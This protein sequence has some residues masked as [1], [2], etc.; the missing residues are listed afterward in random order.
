MAIYHCE[1][2]TISRKSGRSST[3]AAAYRAGEK[4][5]D[6]RTL[7]VFDYTKKK[8]VISAN[9]IMPSNVTKKITRSELWNLAESAEKRKDATVAREYI[10]AIP[11]E[12]PREAQ[13][14]LALKF[15]QEL[16]DRYHI[17]ADVALHAP[18]R[19]GDER[20]VHAHILTTTR[21]I[22]ESGELADKTREL[23]G[24]A[25]GRQQVTLIR[26]LWAQ[27]AN[28]ALERHG[29]SERIDH[30]TLKEQGID[31]QPQIH[32]GVHATQMERR[33]IET[34][35][36]SRNKEIQ[37]HNGELAE[38]KQAITDHNRHIEEYRRA[39]EGQSKSRQADTPTRNPAEP[40]KVPEKGSYTPEQ[41][42]AAKKALNDAQ[43]RHT[44]RLKKQ[45]DEDT[46]KKIAPYQVLYAGKV[47]ERDELEKA[48]PKKKLF[49]RQSVYSGRRHVW[50]AALEAKK[51]E[52]W[53][54]AHAI[55]QLQEEQNRVSFS[56]LPEEAYKLACK[57]HPEA[58][59]IV[60]W[61]KE[62]EK[63]L[64]ELRLRERLKEREKERKQDARSL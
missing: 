32:V 17:A 55:E 60:A 6:G 5:K 28:A 13:R 50:S 42:I 39:T 51:S 1:V 44:E 19:R 12:L 40:T 30:R 58:A 10:I 41:V 59:K 2:K 26:E 56:V 20:N 21:R 36:G 31:R 18:D 61:D 34:E 46:A 11:D 35:K 29:R 63:E 24:M 52:L 38:I 47:K 23:D 49:E 57:E 4:I 25:S 54:I 53:D 62:R 3:A 43:R 14:A 27:L 45:L 33:G 16:A 8:T 48:E 7:E 64:R 37:A 22:T 15:A 9:L